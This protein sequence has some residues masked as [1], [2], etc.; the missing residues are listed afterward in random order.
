MFSFPRTIKFNVTMHFNLIREPKCT[1]PKELYLNFTLKED[2]N[3]KSWWFSF[4]KFLLRGSLIISRFPGMS[5]PK[6][7]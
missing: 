6:G 7:P 4:N 1:T 5:C 2:N 3:K